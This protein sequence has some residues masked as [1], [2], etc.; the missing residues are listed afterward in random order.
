[1]AANEDEE[2]L[3]RSVAL[4][5]A[6]SILLAR[7]R[8]EDAL[9]KQSEWLRITLASIGDPPSVPN[10]AKALGVSE[11]GNTGTATTLPAIVTPTTAPVTATTKPATAT[12]V[13]PTTKP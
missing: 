6:K 7:Q 3:L 9:R 4:Q 11:T 10:L 2:D 13:T 1:M 5:N 8:A 12:T